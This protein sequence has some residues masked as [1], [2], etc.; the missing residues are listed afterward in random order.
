MEWVTHVGSIAS[1]DAKKYRSPHFLR[2]QKMV[3]ILNSWEWELHAAAHQIPND[4]RRPCTQMQK[5]K[6][7]FIQFQKRGALALAAAKYILAWDIQR[8]SFAAYQMTRK[9][10]GR[11]LW[12]GE[13]C[14]VQELPAAVFPSLVFPQPLS[15][16]SFGVLN[17]SYQNFGSV[18]FRR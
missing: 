2:N 3:S 14:G 7:T 4:R 13:K 11:K 18:S 6:S 12:S 16:S 5:P 1:H 9:A 10:T 8:H 15:S 17:L